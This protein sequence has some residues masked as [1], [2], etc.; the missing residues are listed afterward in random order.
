M[1]ISRRQVMHGAA[2]VAAAAP[3]IL[4]QSAKGANDRPT[5]VLIGSGNRGRNLSRAFQKLG[6]VPVGLCDV[7]EPHLQIAKKESPDGAKTFVDYREMMAGLKDIDFVVSGTPDHH[8]KPTLKAALDAGKDIYLEKPL[9]MSIE[10]SQEMVQ[11]VRATDRIVQIGMQRRS[12]DFIHK[13]KQVID[14]GKLGRVHMVKALWNW[15]FNMPLSQQPLDG[16]LNWDLFQGPAPRH[17][18]TPPRFRWWRGFWDYSGGNMTDQGTHL[19]DVVQ[20]MMGAEPPISA[21][22]AGS[23]VSIPGLEAPNIFDAIFEYPDFMATWTLNYRTSYEY[24]WSIKF[25]GEEATMLLDRLGARIYKEPPP[26]EVGWPEGWNLEVAETIKDDANYE[27]HMAN[28]L[29][30]IRTR[31]QPNCPIEKGAEAVCGPHMANLSYKNEAK[32]RRMPDGTVRL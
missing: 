2:T 28:F 20:W 23:K 29:E 25:L 24:D 11:M 9:S 27:A 22:S 10:E 13:A 5:Y 32:V 18:L 4:P 21:Y 31:K 15:H 14:S 19:M 30:C 1:S 17:S 6:A 12:M 16:K 8:H 26:K 3:L 7:Y